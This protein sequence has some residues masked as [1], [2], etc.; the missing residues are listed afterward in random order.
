MRAGLERAI[1]R[2]APRPLAGLVQ[3]VNFRVWLAGTLVGAVADDHAFIR[4]DACADDGIRRRTPEAASRLF[5][6]AMHPPNVRRRDRVAATRH[7][8]YHFSWNSA[9]T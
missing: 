1:E 4:D 7:V 5:E 6:G 9:S 2:R 3:R 8:S